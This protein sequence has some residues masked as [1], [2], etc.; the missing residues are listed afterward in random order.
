MTGTTSADELNDV[1]AIV[2][3]L[4]DRV[5]TTDKVSDLVAEI[6]RLQKEINDSTG[7]LT[8]STMHGAKGLEWGTTYLLGYAEIGN[9]ARRDWQEVEA[10]NL[11]FVA[12]TR[13]KNEL[14]FVTEVAE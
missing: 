9:N 7:S 4:L 14:V 13:A 12:V 1:D 10:R 5:I 8:L 11:R 6:D 2:N 3:T